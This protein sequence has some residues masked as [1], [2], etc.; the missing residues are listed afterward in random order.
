MRRRELLKA[1]ALVPAVSWPSGCGDNARPDL[2][3]VASAVFEVSED[4]FLVWAWAEAGTTALVHV[5]PVDGR[6]AETSVSLDDE[7]GVGVLDVSGLLPDHSYEVDV[8][9]ESGAVLGP[10]VVR[11]APDQNNPRPVRFA[12]S[13][14]YDPSGT[15]FASDV[16]DGVVVHQPEFF[17]SIGD[18]PYTDNG[19]VARTVAEYRQRHLDARTHP[20][21]RSLHE[22]CG[23][24][25][26]YDDHEF[27]NNWDAHFV[28]AEPDRYA[29]AMQVWDEFF[30]LRDALPEIRYRSW[31]WGPLV[32]CFLL[33][34]RRFRSRDAA[35]DDETKTMLGA[36]QLA[37]F[38]SAIAMST[39]TFK[40]VFTSVPLDYTANNNDDWT[41]FLFER[42]QI[43]DHLVAANISGVLFI[44]G[45]QHWFASQVHQYGIRELQVGPLRRGLGMPPAP[46]PEV[47]F[48]FVGFNAAIIDVANDGIT[49]SGVGPDGSSFYT[50]TLTL[51]D[52]TPRP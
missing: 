2:A 8:T 41:G 49:V 11:T 30:P 45:D 12:V 39:A 51:A 25:A 4:R 1:M 48:R 15:Q 26:I 36:A 50:E 3:N 34:C 17:V 38:R 18:F 52:L 21:I 44:S 23:C 29:A 7:S 14:D 22:A 5:T 35:P 40:I 37:W 24:F 9:F 47:K 16:I 20:P 28:A 42:Q 33:D 13:A 32:E 6:V 31:R 10:H 43:F 19:P 27:R 46:T